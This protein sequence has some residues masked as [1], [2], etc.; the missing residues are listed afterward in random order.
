MVGVNGIGGAPE[1]TPE[2]P[3]SARDRKRNEATETRSQDGVRISNEAQEAASVARLS[4]AAGQES[5]IRADRVA[6][7]RE[8]LEKGLYK[9]ENVVVEVAKRLTRLLTLE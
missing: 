4:Q 2:R 6:A 1:P 5:E 7:A 3:A 8:N 9:K